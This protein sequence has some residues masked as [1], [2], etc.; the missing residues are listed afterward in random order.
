[1]KITNDHRE[2]HGVGHG[3]ICKYLLVSIEGD[4]FGPEVTFDTAVLPDMDFTATCKNGNTQLAQRMTITAIMTK[5]LMR[6]LLTACAPP[7]EVD[8]H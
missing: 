7:A 5:S 6:N 2:D 1:M 8:L 4:V 3:V